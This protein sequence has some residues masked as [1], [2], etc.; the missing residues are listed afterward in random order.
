M[1]VIKIF[2]GLCRTQ[3]VLLY[4]N[5]FSIKSQMSKNKS[6]LNGVSHEDSAHKNDNSAI[7]LNKNGQIC[8][9]VH[10][11]PGSQETSIMD[12]QQD[13]VSVR[14][15]AP[16]IDGE[17]NKELLKFMSRLLGL[18]SGDIDL[19]GSKSRKKMLI[20]SNKTT[21]IEDVIKKIKAEC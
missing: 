9:N 6:K 4:N 1:K 7:F 15:S 8:I 3:T 19:E 5:N 21:N 12:I 17:A 13:G 16:P 14:I 10:A 2:S 18:K 11:K 20:I